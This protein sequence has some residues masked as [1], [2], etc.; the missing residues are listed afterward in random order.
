[1]RMKASDVVHN[2][3]ADELYPVPLSRHRHTGSKILFANDLPH[4][5]ALRLALRGLFE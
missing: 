1:M 5:G 3:H 4:P 2:R